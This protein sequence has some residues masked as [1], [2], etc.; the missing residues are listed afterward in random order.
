MKNRKVVNYI[1]LA[2]IISLLIAFA[3]YNIN[4]N[5]AFFTASLVN[6]ITIA[7]AVF[8]SFYL[9]Q[10]RT[11]ERKRKDILLSLL[12]KLQ[13]VIEDEK[14]YNFDA[15]SKDEITMRKRDISNWI[16]IL[17][18]ANPPYIKDEDVK[19]I[20]EKFDE[21]SD[22]IGNHIDDLDALRKLKKDL[23]RPIDLMESKIVKI[24]LDI[25]G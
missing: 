10:K 21:Y 20:R 13:S 3:I 16:K 24:E 4:N 8:V 18:D 11:D 1:I 6:I 5:D 17:E 2:V 19:F 9:V 23:K 14:T 12:T 7:I 25:F 15:Q 22:I